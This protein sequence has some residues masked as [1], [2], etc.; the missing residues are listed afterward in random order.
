MDEAVRHEE[1]DVASQDPEIEENRRKASAEFW[2]ETRKAH[3]DD[4][5]NEM[6][7]IP[8]VFSLPIT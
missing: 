1:E 8:Q 5:L 3:G 4:V 7:I 6:S 2:E